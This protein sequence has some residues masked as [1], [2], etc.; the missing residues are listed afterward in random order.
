MLQVYVR[1]MM[2]G[3]VS[4]FTREHQHADGWLIADVATEG[5]RTNVVVWVPTHLER[6]RSAVDE[7]VRKFDAGEAGTGAVAMALAAVDADERPALIDRLVGER[8]QITHT[9]KLELVPRGDSW[10]IT[11]MIL[12]D[13]DTRASVEAEW[14][15]LGIED[16]PEPK[17]GNMAER[18][19]RL[20][21]GAGVLIG[22]IVVVVYFSTRRPAP[23]RPW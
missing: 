4:T 16:E 9:V 23:P 17:A 20:V 14:E 8:E 3:M 21:G 2:I 18:L 22:I 5:D 15:K 12:N 1:M 19:G 6:S 7:E 11:N 10:R 13:S